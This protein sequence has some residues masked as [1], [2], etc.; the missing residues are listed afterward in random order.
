MSNGRIL[1]VEDE[2]LFAIDLESN[3]DSLGYEVVGKVTNGPDAIAYAENLRPDLIMMDIKLEGKLSGIETSQI[4]KDTL[5]IPVIFLTAHSD[6]QTIEQ[7]KLTEPFGFLLKPLRVDEVNSMIKTALHKHQ[8]ENK[9]RD[10]E[11]RF[12][13]LTDLLPQPVFELNLEGDVTFANKS[14]MDYFSFSHEDLE[15][16]INFF[17]L[18]QKEDLKDVKEEFER[19]LGGGPCVNCEIVTVNKK[20]GEKYSLFYANRIEKHGVVTGIRGTITD[21]SERKEAEKNILTQKLFFEALFEN[22]PEA[23][24][25]TDSDGI[26]VMVNSQFEKMFGYSS[27]EILGQNIDILL[28]PDD[29]YEEA[30]DFTNRVIKEKQRISLE[31]RRQKK[32]G[33]MVDTIIVG[34]PVKTGDN[35][36]FTI[37]IYID[38]SERKMREIETRQIHELYQKTIQNANGVPY[39]L[40]LL[41]KEYEFIGKG[42]EEIL[43]LSYADFDYEYFRN[44]KKEII[45]HDNCDYA[46]YQEKFRNGDLER[47][48]VDFQI[49]TKDGK[50][51]WISDSALP[52][53]SYDEK[54]VIESIGVLQDITRR[55]MIEKQ[56]RIERNRI[57]NY[58]NVAGV[59]FLSLDTKL[60][61]TL[62]NKKGCQILGVPQEKIIGKN[63]INNFLPEKI[64]EKAWAFYDNFQNEQIDMFAKDYKRS[65]Y[66]ESK[67]ITKNHESRTILWNNILLR[68]QDKAISGILCSGIDITEKIIA[69]NNTKKLNAELQRKNHD[70]ERIIYVT[71]HDLRS[72]LVNIEGFGEELHQDVETILKE[73]ER[74]ATIDECREK[75]NKIV[76]H[77]IPESLGYIKN[78]V[79]KIESLLSALL[80]LSR[81]G[82]QE[83]N[84]VKI[85]MNELFES[86]LSTFEYRIKRNN[87]NL[88]IGNLPDCYADRKQINQLFS[89]LIAN[90]LKFL[91]PDRPG[92]I[93]IKGRGTEKNSY[94]YVRDNGIGIKNED[95]EKIFEIFKRVHSNKSIEGEGLGLSIVRRILEKNHGDIKVESAYGEW[96]KFTII[97]PG[98]RIKD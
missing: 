1:V 34:S 19:V 46:T 14:F 21:I 96:T 55:K 91:H 3:L 68:D 54:H 15:W 45:V 6:I 80:Q 62:I 90:C 12:R 4:I 43:G 36:N 65:A 87:I 29:Y 22:S 33:D 16:K 59:V 5:D 41:T 18:F 84:I 53:Y 35:I 70:L 92:E 17:D 64:R 67:V 76:K 58:L 52:V 74:S 69:E 60:N 85:D 26:I 47:Y 2:L 31:T 27:D 28:A 44:I 78:S 25:S 40:N 39:R 51:R 32:S 8:I 66:F 13:D 73:I 83:L 63:W 94:Y 56:L 98:E 95:R 86:I 50:E 77:E 9:L 72:P 79:V 61:V 57:Q 20:G 48:Q 37:G 49:F 71:S 38:I 30:V 7:A 75:I 88:K 42:L 81:L 11:K 97:L 24:V 23:I 10:S 82:R 89:N 93:E